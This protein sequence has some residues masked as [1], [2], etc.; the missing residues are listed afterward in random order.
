MCERTFFIN[1]APGHLTVGPT[2]GLTRDELS[3]P[4]E[5]VQKVEPKGIGVE[6]DR[7][8]LCSYYTYL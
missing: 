5:L 6:T 4:E 1:V 8:R 7:K 3:Y 2:G